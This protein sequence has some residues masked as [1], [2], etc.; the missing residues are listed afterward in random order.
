MALP[1]LAPTI[2]RRM[3]PRD[4]LDIYLVLTQGE[5]LRDILQPGEEVVSFSVG[6]SAEA[7]AAGLQL[8]TGS[9]APRYADLVFYALLSVAGTMQG[10]AIFVGAGLLVGV[11]ITFTTNFDDRQKTY[12][13]GVKVVKK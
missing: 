5:T 3:D 9:K 2:P 7:A 4:K 11:E 6:L 13:V 10:A 12:T 8:G 1:L